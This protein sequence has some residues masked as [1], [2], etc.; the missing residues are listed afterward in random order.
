MS[1][2]IGLIFIGVIACALFVWYLYQRSQS[3]SA[4]NTEEPVDDGY[5]DLLLTGLM[6]EEIYD[7][8]NEESSDDMDADGYDDGFGGGYD[9]SSG[10]E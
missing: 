1:L 5:E 6:L 7:D 4:D 8:D 2:A 9:D 3:E 10:L